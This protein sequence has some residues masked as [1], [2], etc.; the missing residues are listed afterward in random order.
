MALEYVEPAKGRRNCIQC[1]DKLVGCIL[2]EAWHFVTFIFISI[3]IIRNS[4]EVMLC[5]F[6]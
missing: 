2:I 3:G 5:E 1:L 4:S 6:L